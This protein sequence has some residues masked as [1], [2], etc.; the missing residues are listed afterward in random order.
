[1]AKC[2]HCGKILNG[3]DIHKDHYIPKCAGGTDDDINIVYACSKCNLN[4]NG[5]L[6]A[7]KTQKQWA[8]LA[9]LVLTMDKS[10]NF[11]VFVHEFGKCKSWMSLWNGEF[12]DTLDENRKTPL[13]IQKYLRRFKNKKEAPLS[14]ELIHN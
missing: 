8:A 3:F 6:I 5:H 2:F 14:F 1:M 4:K 7:P 12:G 10:V 9:F 13:K 11:D